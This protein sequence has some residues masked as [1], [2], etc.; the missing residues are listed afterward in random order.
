MARFRPPGD[1]PVCGEFVAAGA[2]AC[3][4]CGSCEK[5]GWNDAADYDGL[6]LP[7]EAFEDEPRRPAENGHFLQRVWWSVAV[8]LLLVTIWY[9]FQPGR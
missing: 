1:C 4:D 8:V 3:R 6:D 2:K 9:L 5:T 7:D